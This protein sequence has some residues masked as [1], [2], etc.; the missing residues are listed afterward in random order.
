[1]EIFTGQEQDTDL[2]PSVATIGFF[3]G[4]HIGHRHL[5]D[6]VCRVA[7][8]HGLASM[9]VTFPVHPR[10]VMQT[11]YRPQLLTTFEEKCAL[12]EKTGVD[13]C[14]A[15]PFTPQL[16]ALTAY[17]FMQMMYERLHVRMLVIGYDHRFGHNRS[18]DF[19]DYC[20]YG[21]KLGM[22]VVRADAC[23]KGGVH[24]SSSVIR[25]LLCEGEVRMA[26]QCLGYD[27][28]ITGSVTGGHRIGRTLGYPTANLQVEEADK[29]IPADGVYAARAWVEGVPYKAMVNIGLRPTIGAEE[30][31]T[32]EA[33]ILHYDGNLYG[34]MLRLE[35]VTR[36][37][38]EH[39]FA[40]REALSAR[41]RQD[42]EETERVFKSEK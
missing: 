26:A 12:L 39:K 25:L 10:K 31:R 40:D 37:R 28:F 29:L 8:E 17:E 27:Y 14:V 9:L 32:I 13:Y 21:E 30:E 33:H 5:I 15:M 20:R 6:Q 2:R 35:F 1:M 19:T 3:D 11:S 18:E 22:K 23:I 7:G 36:I 16:A 41:L 34:R 24:V 4:V 38:D 42:A